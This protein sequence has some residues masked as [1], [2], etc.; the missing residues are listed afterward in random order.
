MVFDARFELV[1]ASINVTIIS[2]IFLVIDINIADEQLNSQTLHLSIETFR[3]SCSVVNCLSTKMTDPNITL[4][5]LPT[6]SS[7]MPDSYQHIVKKRRAAW[8]ETINYGKTPVQEI[9]ICEKHFHFGK[10]HL[11]RIHFTIS[12]QLTKFHLKRNACKCL[13]LLPRR[14]G[15]AFHMYSCR[16]RCH[17]RVQVLHRKYGLLV[18]EMKYCVHYRISTVTILQAFRRFWR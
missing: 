18:Y 2:L 9:Q 17:R 4:Y 6:C 11:S 1:C 16:R 10:S 8:L 12:F 3:V 15:A 7:Y 13:E 14:L 5:P